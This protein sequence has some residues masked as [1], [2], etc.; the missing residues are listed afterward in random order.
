MPACWESG[1]FW[2]T[3]ECI[4][5]PAISG[6]RAVPSLRKVS[7]PTV[8]CC[9]L[10]DLPVCEFWKERGVLKPCQE[11]QSSLWCIPHTCMGAATAVSPKSSFFSLCPNVTPQVSLLGHF[12]SFCFLIFLVRPHPNPPIASVRRGCGFYSPHTKADA[13]LEIVAHGNIA[14]S[15]SLVLEMRHFISDHGLKTI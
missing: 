1:D 4:Y 13:E 9:L 8:T 10:L 2:D 7:K 15:A 5:F 11:G 12:G 3:N 14:L 6:E